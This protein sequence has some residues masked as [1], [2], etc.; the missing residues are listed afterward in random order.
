VSAAGRG[1]TVNL[2]HDEGV[3]PGTTAERLTRLP[4]AVSPE[5]T[6]ILRTPAAR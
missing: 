6:M 3:R 1:G 5:G 4:A 2:E